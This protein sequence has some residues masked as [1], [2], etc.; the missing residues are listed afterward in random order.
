MQ[1]PQCG[2]SLA[3]MFSRDD[4]SGDWQGTP[5]CEFTRKVVARMQE[6][7]AEDRETAQRLEEAEPRCKHCNKTV[8]EHTEVVTWQCHSGETYFDPNSE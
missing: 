7:L 5:C 1:C 2:A 3:E 4:D 8:Y 6:Q